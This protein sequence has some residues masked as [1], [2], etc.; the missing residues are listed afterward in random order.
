MPLQE[1][2]IAQLKQVL[3]HKIKKKTELVITVNKEMMAGIRVKIGD[4][5]MDNSA[6]ARL[7]N[8]KE[9]VVRSEFTSKRGEGE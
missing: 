3:E 6:S 9:T 8:L 5:V 1:E 7:A 2:D 4:Q